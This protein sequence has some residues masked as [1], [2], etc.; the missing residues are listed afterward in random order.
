MRFGRQKL[1]KICG[2]KNRQG[3][4]CQCKLLFKSGRCRFHGGLSTGPKTEE[5]KARS[6]L[7]LRLTQ[8]WR[9][10]EAAHALTGITIFRLRPP[11]KRI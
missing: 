9:K 2:A 5:G 11:R 1:R 3:Q 10:S 7:N 4:A 6:L 8:S